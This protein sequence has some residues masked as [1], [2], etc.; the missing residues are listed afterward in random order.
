[1][2]MSCN[3]NYKIINRVCMAFKL[4]ERQLDLLEG[5]F[6]LI[7]RPTLAIVGVLVI[8]YWLTCDILIP[9]LLG[10]KDDI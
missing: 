8:G 2:S 7:A 6:M 4:T 3:L 10:K 5:P 1:M 9:K